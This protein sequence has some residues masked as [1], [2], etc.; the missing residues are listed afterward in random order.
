LNIYWYDAPKARTYSLRIPRIYHCRRDLMQGLGVFS[1]YDRIKSLV[2]WT[3]KEHSPTIYC[4]M[5]KNG[6]F[7]NYV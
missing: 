5:Q 1:H 2:F 3:Y 6:D 4:V 7:V